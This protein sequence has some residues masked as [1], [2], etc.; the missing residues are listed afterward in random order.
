M[1]A[2]HYTNLLIVSAMAFL[3]PLSLG[4]AR[5][6]RMPSIVVEIVLGIVVGPSVLGWVTVDAPVRILNL[7]GLAFLL[8]LAGLEVDIGRLRGRTLV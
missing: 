3:A 1:P 8:F 7:I 2:T 6:L 4:F 5:R